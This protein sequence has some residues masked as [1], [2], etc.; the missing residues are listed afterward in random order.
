MKRGQQ[1]LLLAACCAALLSWSCVDGLIEGLYCGKHNCYDVLGIDR[2]AD[3]ADV[4][5]AYRRLAV[6][7]HP[8]KTKEPG[9]R[10]KFQ[11]ITTAYEILKDEEER[12]NYNYMLEN[13]EQVYR[14]YYHY[15][16]KRVAPKI[17]V[18]VVI[19]V[20]ITII[21]VIQYFGWWN[22]YNNAMEAALRMPK[23]RVKAREM[24]KQRGLLHNL[25]RRRMPRSHARETEEGILREI[26]EQN[27][28]ILGGYSR[29]SILDVLWLKLLLSPYYIGRYVLWYTHWVWRFNMMGMEYSLREHIY[30][31]RRRLKLSETQWE[32]FEQAQ[33]DELVGRQLW[34]DDKWAE[35]QEEQDNEQKVKLAENN[36]YKRYRRYMKSHKP[37]RMSFE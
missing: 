11:L 4:R 37:G 5:K 10:E 20:S 36:R 12:T 34:L 31:T 33:R 8:D 15:Y 23:Y 29:P 13:P 16:K 35:F 9:S 19:A 7:Y 22:S 30:L 28:N 3:A 18:R 26:L 32:A 21:S 1:L 27:L 6:K 24:A 25:E 17:D 2:S 14:H